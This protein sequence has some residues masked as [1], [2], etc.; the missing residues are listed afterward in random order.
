[1]KRDTFA[2]TLAAKNICQ[3]LTAQRR[4]ETLSRPPLIGGES[5]SVSRPTDTLAKT[6]CRS[7]TG[8]CTP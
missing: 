2:E 1:M 3:S 4:D 7:L 5:V 6:R 8:S